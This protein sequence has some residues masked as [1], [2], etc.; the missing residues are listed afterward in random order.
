M[1][2]LSL[3]LFVICLLPPTAQAQT[4][5]PP[6]ATQP[7]APA[8]ADAA[9]PKANDQKIICVVQDPSGATRLQSKRVC[10][11]EQEWNKLGGIPR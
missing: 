8:A 1:R 9:A 4:D 7:A 6:P 10:H 3:A 5:T 11:T 2:H